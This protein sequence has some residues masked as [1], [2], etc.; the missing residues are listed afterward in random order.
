MKPRYQHD[1][2]DEDR[3]LG[4]FEVWDLW[5]QVSN[6]PNYFYA[7]NGSNTYTV[8]ATLRAIKLQRGR[9]YYQAWLYALSLINDPSISPNSS[10]PGKMVEGNVEVPF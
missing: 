2:A 9:P 3:F 6:D 1:Y 10:G 7:K 4:Y 8:E 5:L